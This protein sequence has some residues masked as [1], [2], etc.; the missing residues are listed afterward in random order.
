M[1]ENKAVNIICM[2][3]GDK[4]GAEYVNKLYAMVKRNITIPFQFVC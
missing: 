4:Y 1:E 2:K 3:W